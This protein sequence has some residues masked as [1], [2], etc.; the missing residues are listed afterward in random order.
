MAKMKQNTPYTSRPPL[1]QARE[2]ACVEKILE[3]VS[4]VA[5]I[6][7]AFGGIGM[8]GQ[9]LSERFPNALIDSY[10]LDAE[11][12]YRY[13]DRNLLNVTIN[14]ADTLTQSGKFEAASLDFNRFPLLDL[15]RKEGEFQQR[16]LSKVFNQ[17]PDW[18]H[19]T[20]SSCSK[21]H[22]NWKSYGLKEPDWDGYVE[23]L[24]QAFQERWGYRIV[25]W[26]KH[27]RAA[28]FIFV[29]KGKEM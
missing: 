11:C 8:L 16:V 7:E 25:T 18:V 20:D 17:N 1:E 4:P 15:N 12:V 9:V 23:K 5:S 10:E 28:Y 26:D 6:Y 27:S 29:P 22:L 13:R 14:H 21:L 24:D 2:K 3:Q 19:V